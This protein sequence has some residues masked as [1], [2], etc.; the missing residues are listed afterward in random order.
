ML[1]WFYTY[2]KGDF[3]KKGWNDVYV[4]LLLSGFYFAMAISVKWTALYGAMAVLVLFLLLKKDELK[5]G[6]SRK[7]FF[8]PF[9]LTPLLVM[10][11]SFIIIGFFIYVLSYTPTMGVPG[12]GSGLEMVF[13]YQG[14]ML[15]YHETL[16]AT[17]PFSSPWWSWIFMIKPV[18]IYTLS[19]P[20]ENTVS[21]IVAMGNPAIWWISIP[22]LFF[23]LW[24][25][26]K[27]NDSTCRF[28]AVVFHFQLL[29]Y[30]FIGRVLFLYHMMINVPFMILSITY[31]L[32]I[33][34]YKNVTV[35]LH[36]GAIMAIV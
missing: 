18:W 35:T 8:T 27:E 13:R 6:H 32:N 29:P 16:T 34:W 10:F 22:F 33:L 15:K 1:Y 23:V 5:A 17:H 26:I 9:L 30:L 4:P 36:V 25:W 3:F 2:Y 7:S 20:V 12:E 19:N 11:I 21:N 24:K 28:L 31:G 14:N